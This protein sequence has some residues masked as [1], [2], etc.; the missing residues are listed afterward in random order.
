M[1]LRRLKWLAVVAPL[2]FL[3]GVDLLRH[4]VLPDLLHSWP[5]QLVIVGIVL[6]GVLLFTGAVFRIVERTQDG[7]VRR[8]RELLALHE[9]GLAIPSELS[10]ETVL[11]KAVDQAR[12]LVGA[13]YGAL[14]ILRDGGGI[15]LFI[16]SGLSA[17]ERARIGPP[18]QGRGLLG[19]VLNEGQ[20]LRLP[21]LARD[22]R[23]IGFPPH[24]PPMHSL[25]AV[26][27]VAAGVIVGNLYL[28][29]KV[30]ADGFT[31]DDEEI[32]LRFAT[33]VALAITNARLHRQ[34]E[35]FAITEERERIAREMHDG[36]AQVL[37]YVNTKAQA[38]Q[39]LIG[40]GQ[41]E[42]A[43]TQ[44]GQL[45]DAAR[46]AYVDVRENILA[47]RTSVSPERPFMDTLRLYVEAW[48]DQSGV[49]T[50]LS[51]SLDGASALGPAGEL[52]LLR[53]V[54][55]ALANVRKHAGASHAWVRVDRDG[56]HLVVTIEDDGAGFDPGALTRGAFPRFGLATMR[57]R[58]ESVGGTLDVDSAPGRGTRVMVRVPAA[59]RQ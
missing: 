32:L 4:T 58:A 38:A 8:N 26:P 12:E 30:Q 15:D 41:P 2:A 51:T 9:A 18:P 16:T 14:S 28:A 24:H 44:I 57:E 55:E 22:P 56:S 23:S 36:L 42:R 49:S 27:V 46:D 20:R 13:R 35:A 17:E 37:G 43:S 21:D 39:E 5:G 3:V 6:V 54:Q 48:Q 1:T 11:Q 7:L 53:I 25:L 34:V 33:Q 10:L 31:L 29:E 45:A 19:V 47:L 52:Q 40:S 50:E 59:A